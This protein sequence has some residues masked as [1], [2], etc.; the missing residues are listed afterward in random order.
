MDD[1]IYEITKQMATCDAIVELL[2]NE[3]DSAFTSISLAVDVYAH[4]MG[5]SSSRAWDWLYTVAK[6]V[7]K[8]EGEY[9]EIQRKQS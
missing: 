4:R 2:P 5:I 1:F 3:I 6:E 7:I 9:G 8:Q